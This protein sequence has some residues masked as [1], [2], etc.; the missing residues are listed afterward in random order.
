MSIA[1]LILAHQH[2]QALRRLC[3]QLTREGDGCWI[4]LDASADATTFQ[5]ALADLPGIRWLDTRQRVWWAG[6]GFVDAATHLIEAALQDPAV[7]HLALL[8]ASCYP[9]RPLSALRQYLA[10]SA[11]EHIGYRAIDEQHRFWNRYH[12]F[13]F[14]DHEWLNPRGAAVQADGQQS[15]RQYLGDFVRDQKL[16]QPPVRLP[17][18]VGSTWWVLSRAAATWVSTKYAREP[19]WRKRFRFTRNADEAVYTTLLAHSPFA[20]RCK[21]NLHHIDWTV[22]PGPK[23]L[24]LE[25][26]PTIAASG[27]FFVRKTDPV[28]SAALLDRLD[29]ALDAAGG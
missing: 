6:S 20:T 1:F 9:C 15:L 18:H 2:P 17:L 8:S 16:T 14:M 26:W 24:T 28:L 7:E 11:H 23:T 13:H 5:A 21:G 25:D 22:Q 10:T 4:H 12:R 29:Q 3:Q 19:Y 27:K